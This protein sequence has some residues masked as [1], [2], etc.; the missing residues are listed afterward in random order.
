MSSQGG[1]RSGRGY[2]T[3][4]EPGKRT[5]GGDRS[6]VPC[7]RSSFDGLQQ[8]R[9]NEPADAEQRAGR[10]DCTSLRAAVQSRW[11]AFEPLIQGAPICWRAEATCAAAK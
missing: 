2:G 11:P 7:R 4:Q 10:A 8:Q 1:N 3:D 6:G 9:A 5:Q